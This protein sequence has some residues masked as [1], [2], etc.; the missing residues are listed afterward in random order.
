M[1]GVRAEG[2]EGDGGPACSRLKPPECRRK[3]RAAHPPSVLLQ[4]CSDSQGEES[5]R[6]TEGAAYTRIIAPGIQAATASLAVSTKRA[7]AV[8]SLTARSA[9]ILR[10]MLTPALLRPWI[11]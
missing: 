7:N 4:L 5:A 1:P 9:S 3:R 10:S 6:A 2:P 8:L 11:S